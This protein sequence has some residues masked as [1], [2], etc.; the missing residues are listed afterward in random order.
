[1]A[2]ARAQVPR[3]ADDLLA[4][5]RELPPEEL[6][7]FQRQYA[8]WSKQDHDRNGA[9]SD[10]A[11]EEALQAVIR[12]NSTLPAAEQPR[13]NRLR[14]KRQAAKLTEAE[15]KQLQALWRRVEQMNAAR[16]E[17]LGELARR[18]GTDV[19]TVMRQLGIPENRD[20]F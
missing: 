14:R 15:E 4:A 3:T 7:E 5:V 19:R 17:T 9:P 6:R 11:D 1:M 16:L 10:R 12:E 20:V 18:R 2:T 13:F 8:A